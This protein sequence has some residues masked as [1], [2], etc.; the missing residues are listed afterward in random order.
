MYPDG[1]A[2]TCTQDDCRISK[3]LW[4]EV[5]DNFQI[6]NSFPNVILNAEVVI[7]GYTG[8]NSVIAVGFNHLIILI[9][10]YI[11]KC[12]KQNR[13]PTFHGAKAYCKYYKELDEFRS[14]DGLPKWRFLDGLT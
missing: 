9:K 6:L 7:L 3:N 2:G 14:G 1:D 4:Q 10:K 5:F 12:K 13:R 8:E 11:F